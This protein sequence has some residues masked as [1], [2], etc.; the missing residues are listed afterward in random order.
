MTSAMPE[1]VKQKVDLHTHILPR[2]WPNLRDRYGYGGFVHLEHHGPGCARMTIDGNL[3]RAIEDHCWDPRRRLEDCDRHGV[4]VQVLSTV[5]VMFSY[6]AKPEHGHDLAR[7]LND[8]LAGVVREYPRRVA[9]LG[10]LPMQ[11]PDLAV[12]ELDRC[13]RALGLC[14]VQI[15]RHVNGMNLDHPSLF[16]VFEAPDRLWAAVFFPPLALLAKERLGK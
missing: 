6:W 16:P 4:T 14:V 5:P 10:T 7:L 12:R 3:F 1:G 11:A 8:H 2:E 15:G 9:G 13:M